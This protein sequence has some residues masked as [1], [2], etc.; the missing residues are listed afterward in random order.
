MIAPSTP[1]SA[2]FLTAVAGSVENWLVT[3]Q[4]NSSTEKSST[5]KIKLVRQYCLEMCRHLDSGSMPQPTPGAPHF[6]QKP[7]NRQTSFPFHLSFLSIQAVQNY[8]M[9]L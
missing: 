2:S 6:P 7:S 1:C 9:V 5:E 3:N 8:L 4:A